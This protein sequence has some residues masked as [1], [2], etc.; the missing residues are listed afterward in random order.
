[1]QLNIFLEKKNFTSSSYLHIIKTTHYN[2]I[3]PGNFH[4]D[5]YRRRHQIKMEQTQQLNQQLRGV[6]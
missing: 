2:P 3:Y 5:Q 1:M 6:A 4:S